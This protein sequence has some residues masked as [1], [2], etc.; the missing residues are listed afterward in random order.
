MRGDVN[1]RKLFHRGLAL[2]LAVTA[3]AAAWLLLPP[4]QEALTA[5]YAADLAQPLP[6]DAQAQYRYIRRHLQQPFTGYARH[7]TLISAFSVVALSHMACGLLNTAQAQP[8]LRAEVLPLLAETVRRA[9]HPAVSRYG[10]D[11]RT[12]TD[13]GDHN[14]YLTHLNLAVGCYRAVSGD[15]Q[16]D[17]LHHRLAVHLRSRT[18]RDG[19]WHAQ[20][21]AFPVKWPADQAATL[22]SLALYDRCFGTRLADEPVAGWLQYLATQATDTATG[23]PYSCLMPLPHAQVPRGCALSWSLLY[24]AQFAPAEAGRL[25]RRYREHYWQEWLGLGGFREWPHGSDYGVSVD[26]GLIIR[27]FGMTA[28]GFGLGATRLHGDARAYGLLRRMTATVGLP[29]GGDVRAHRLAPLLGEA[30]LF[31][32][33]TA[34]RWFA[35]SPPSPPP[36]ALPFPR[37]NAAAFLLLVAWLVLSLW[38]AVRWWRRG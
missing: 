28:S 5:D 4:W 25:Y 3:L 8:E 23:L 15:T 31:H 32:G 16:Y 35:P 13:W 22:A 34:R 17:G 29:Y 9:L 37:L 10:A 18:L 24:M 38:R 30:I 20:S 1:G 21:F 12:V 36:A 6:P 19:D 26:S 14:L 7:E 2:L 27:G 11:P 33:M